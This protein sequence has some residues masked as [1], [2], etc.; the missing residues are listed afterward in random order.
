MK[1]L[2]LYLSIFVLF[3]NTI[4]GQDIDAT[5]ARTERAIAEYF[6]L[7]RENIYAQF[8]K[9]IFFTT[10]QIWFKGYVFN[11]KNNTPFFETSNVF[12]ILS[13]NAGN[14]I[15]EQL[16]FSY[17]GTFSGSFKLGKQLE[18]GQYHIQFYTNWMNNFTEDESAFYHIEVINEENSIIRDRTT[19]DYSKI[20]IA[21]STGGGQ[22]IEGINNHVGVKIADCNGNPI[23]VT[24]GKVVNSRGEVIK[25]FILNKSGYGQFNITPSTEVYKAVFSINGQIVESVL[26]KAVLKG[27]GLEVNNYALQGKTILKLRT[28]LRTLENA[29]EKTFTIAIHQND[30]SSIFNITLSGKSLEREIIIP[31][32]SLFKGINTIRVLNQ[33]LEQV[34]VRNIFEFPTDDSGLNLQV[35]EKLDDNLTFTGKITYP[36]ANLSISVL[37][38]KTA[39]TNLSSDIIGAFMINPYCNENIFNAGELLKGATKARRYELDLFLLNQTSGK[40]D[41]KNIIAGGPKKVHDFDIGLTIKGTLN[42][43]I[44]EKKKHRMHLSSPISLISNYSEI[45]PKNE[46]IFNN[47]VFSDSTSMNFNLLKLPSVPV[48]TKVYHQVLNRKRRYNKMFKPDGAICESRTIRLN[49]SELPILATNIIALDNIDIA[50]KPKSQLVYK[51]RYGNA[52][53]RGYKISGED[54]GID[55]LTYI[56]SRG[57]NVQFSMGEVSISG[58]LKTSV[59]GQA[60]TPEIYINGRQLI[61]FDELQ[62]VKMDEVDEIYLNPHAIVA[63][64]KNNMGVIKIYMKKM[65]FGNQKSLSKS[66]MI[67][68]GFAR[69]DAFEN[70]LY[71]STSDKGFEN[72]GVIQWIPTVLTDENGHFKFQIPNTDVKTLK[73][74]IEGFTADGR[75]ISETKVITIN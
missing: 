38:E 12:A 75:L 39:A 68:D 48:D 9:T 52:N 74:K 71:L 6:F 43:S 20:N 49:P 45:S 55:L 16:L 72:Y 60:T 23:P 46:F 11:K 25:N 51:N 36:N 53:L 14:V 58:R 70:P 22:F 1:N 15:K 40:Y 19:P 59:N 42:Q 4:R 30:K 56:G 24:E 66:L 47:L 10:E 69:I 17:N 44:S 3:F 65:D 63:S 73:I 35:Q 13:D 27:I 5:N 21:F 41:W 7:D 33:E 34:A 64:I 54:S 29:E 32:D 62:D 2:K 8:D 50:G 31:S 37:P 67:A 26:P 28:N 61:T 18:S 57:F